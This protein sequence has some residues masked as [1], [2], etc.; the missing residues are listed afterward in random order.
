M[1]VIR[2][3]KSIRTFIKGKSTQNNF[4]HPPSFLPSKAIYHDLGIW[5]LTGMG[6][7]LMGRSALVIALW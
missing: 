7:H 4:L 5:S 3:E 6:C 1:F 2:R